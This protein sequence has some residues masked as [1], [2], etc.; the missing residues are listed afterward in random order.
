MQAGRGGDL[1]M[2]L[3]VRAFIAAHR[4]DADACRR[5]AAEAIA[6]GERR[7]F[8]TAVVTARSALG[9]L[10]LSLGEHALAAAELAELERETV[11]A[12]VGNPGGMRFIPDY[13]EALAGLGE[14]DRARSVIDRY[15]AHA[16]RLDRPAARASALRCHGLIDA[17]AGDTDGA[18][19]AFAAALEQHDRLVLPI[20]RARTLLAHGA[21]LRR[22][23]QKT[24]ARASL[25]EALEVFTT[26]G[27]K[28]FAAAT[29]AGARADRRPRRVTRRPDTERA[30]GRRA[31]RRGPDQPP[32]RGGPIRQR[33]HGRGSSLA[34]LREARG[35]LPIAA[36]APAANGTRNPL[37]AGGASS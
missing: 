15:Q 24:A 32:G 21:L 12:G 20:D 22:A 5:L 14:L 9:L 8:K 25:D 2:V 37:T 35:A 7:S 23:K 13:T 17:A 10:A 4:G 19:R 3:A 30:P 26:T 28:L 34:H 11:A 36:G 31:G 18:L 33:A 6:A 16:V 29:G 27:A 1:A